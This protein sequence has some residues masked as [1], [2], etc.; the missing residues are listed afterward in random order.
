MTITSNQSSQ[1]PKK[2]NVCYETKKGQVM[3]VVCG[4][5]VSETSTNTIINKAIYFRIDLVNRTIT[6]AN[7]AQ[8]VQDVDFKRSIENITFNIYN[9]FIQP[10]LIQKEQD[11]MNNATKWK[12]VAILAK[13]TYLNMKKYLEAH[14][15]KMEK[16]H[17]SKIAHIDQFIGYHYNLYRVAIKKPFLVQNDVRNEMKSPQA[18]L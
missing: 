18:L 11:L 14:P 3:Y 16:G 13:G 9:E 5:I 12:N 1:S 6:K 8:F 7:L 17:K 15:N 10:P 4:S 2:A